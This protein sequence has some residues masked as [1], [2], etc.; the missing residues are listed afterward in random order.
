[1]KYIDIHAHAYRKPLP[2]VTRFCS[3]GELRA[4]YDAA[5]IGAGILLPVVNPE[6]YLPQ[7]NEDILDMVAEYPGRF[8]AFCNVDPR[9]LTFRADAPL[10]KV[11]CYY[12]DRG[13]R[14]VGEIM[15]NMRMDDPLVQN[16]FRCAEIAKLPVTC[17]GSD[18]VG[19]D[20]GLYDDYGLPLLEKTLQKFPNLDVIGH[21]PIFWA[22]YARFAPR[23]KRKPEFLADGTQEALYVPGT[24]IEGEGAMQ[25]LLR[26][27]EHLYVELS[28]GAGQLQ[29]D[30]D[31]AAAFLTEFQDR[32]F[33][34][35]DLCNP[36]HPFR[37]LEVME[38]L[39]GAKK[40]S[41]EVFS[42]IM[43]KNAVRFF[44]LEL[45]E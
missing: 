12:R 27:Y 43:R 10:D 32:I 7:S 6:V 34:G 26:R 14:G 22:D 13:C 19:A 42:K 16:L 38:R 8:F 30:S 33:F 41:G 21:G 18:R 15:P 24:P 28:D 45:P 39:H 3:P 4:R 5:G 40:I 35:T 44:H 17:D 31:F 20:F 29:R 1:M 23:Y 25:P 2:F 37:I 9:A 11:L 36:E